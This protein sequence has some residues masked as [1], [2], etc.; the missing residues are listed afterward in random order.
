MTRQRAPTRRTTHP[1]AERERLEETAAQLSLPPAELGHELAAAD[2]ASRARAMGG[3]QAQAGNAAL[4]GLLGGTGHAAG[5]GMGQGGIATS[6]TELAITRDVAD[7]DLAG[8]S[9]ELVP[10]DTGAS[11]NVTETV[12]PVAESSYRVNASSLADVVADIGGR[13]EAGHVGW[14]P[15]LDF[16]QTDGTIDTVTINVSI[17]LEM[18]AWSPPSKMLPKARAEWTRWYAALRAHEQGHI[19]LVHEAFDGLAARILRQPVDRGQRLFASAK[20]SLAT[21][22]RAYDGR[23]GH[24]IKQGTV[25]DVSIEQR[26]LDEERRKREEAEK[27][28]KRE[29]AVPTVGDEDE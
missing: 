13:D 7:E 9:D 16:H 19:D 20:T 8:P 11:T 14:V 10:L 22:S 21:K 4:G 24:G 25:M 23:T 2:G 26:E 17:D 29:P 12:G 6:T 28:R 27:A 1:G 3:L 5:V 15:T 18:P